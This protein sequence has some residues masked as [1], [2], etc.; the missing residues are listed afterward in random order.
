MANFSLKMYILFTLIHSTA[1]LKMFPLH[2]IFQI[3]YA[4]SVETKG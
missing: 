1:D 2:C 4:E 3:L